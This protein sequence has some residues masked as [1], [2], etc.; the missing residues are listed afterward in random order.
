MP[1]SRR[2]PL[3][4]DVRR[5]WP[6][7]LLLMPAFLMMFL[8]TY[9]PALQALY[10]SFFNWWP[11]SYN[12]FVG[13]RN[14]E[15]LFRW[16]VFWWSWGNWAKFAV[17][18]FTAPFLM[19]FVMAECIFNLRNRSMQAFWRMAVIVPS[20]IPGIVT[21][22]LWRWMYQL[23][24]GFNV[25]LEMVGLGHLV[26]PWLGQPDT[27]LYAMMFVGFPWAIGASVLIVLAGLENISS[28]VMDAS[29]I[30]GCGRFRRIFAID[31]PNITG[32]IRLFLVFGIIGIFQEFSRFLAMT[33]GGPYFATSVP[34]L[35]MFFKAGFRGVRSESATGATSHG[36]SAAIATILFILILIFSLLTH[37]FLRGDTE[38]KGAKN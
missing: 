4:L 34:A 14:Y 1:T 13:F 20:L 11:G 6:L 5:S 32:V 10:E 16:E 23:D 2:R 9:Y 24:G 15:R 31:L 30:D 3:W 7:Y 26:A 37:R 27:A 33:G 29:T 36:E 18:H 28:D 17:F 21:F 38:A 22:V 8:F 19:P 25:I 12:E 35:L